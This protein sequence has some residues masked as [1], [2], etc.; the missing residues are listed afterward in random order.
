MGR[1][2][3]YRQQRDRSA[4]PT[5]PQHRNTRG[6]R[7]GPRDSSNYSEGVSGDVNITGRRRN[8]K[9]NEDRGYRGGSHASRYNGQ[10]GN[11]YPRPYKEREGFGKV[12]SR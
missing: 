7:Y 6:S 12:H 5:T 1:P 8:P 4:N 9:M 2:K 3:S 10:Q 11:H